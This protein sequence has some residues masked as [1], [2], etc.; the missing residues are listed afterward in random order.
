MIWQEFQVGYNF[1]SQLEKDPTF[2]SQLS[3]C[4]AQ[5]T[6][7]YRIKTIPVQVQT[8]PRFWGGHLYQKKNP[9]PVPPKPIQK[10]NSSPQKKKKKT[11][12]LHPHH[13]DFIIFLPRLL[14]AQT[15]AWP[16]A[17]AASLCASSSFKPYRSPALMDHVW[18]TL[19]RRLGR[20]VVESH[21]VGPGMFRKHFGV[22]HWRKPWWYRDVSEK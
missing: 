18:A 19:G 2:T 10:H 11:P 4:A 1:R 13:W 20:W 22:Q 12:Q 5:T 16:S 8:S 7:I 3:R 9:T 21:G 6:V 14:G 15:E 17:L